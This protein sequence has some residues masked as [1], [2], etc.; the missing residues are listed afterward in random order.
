MESGE[1][2]V[3]EATSRDGEVLAELRAIML[4]SIF[5]GQIDVDDER[6]V[7]LEYF[8]GWDGREPYCLIAEENDRVAGTIACSFFPHFPSSRNP[9]GK[10]ALVHNLCVFEEFRGRGIGRNLVRAI[11]FECR[12]RQVGR[13]NLYASE[14]GRGIYESFGFREERPFCPEM[15][16]HQPDLLSLDL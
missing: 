2:V 12:R 5:A 1:Q 10:L 7:N 13:V 4:A 16:L 8:R 6:R 15:R 3:R 9:T 11:L 14:M